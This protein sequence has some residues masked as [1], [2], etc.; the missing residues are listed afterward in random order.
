MNSH[1]Q[2]PVLIGHVLEGDIS[3][4]TGIVEENIDATIVLDGCLDDSVAVLDAV[5]VGNCFAACG[6]NFVDNYIGGVRTLDL[7]GT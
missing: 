2:I 4:N 6:F 5:V 1:N 7:N 3:Q